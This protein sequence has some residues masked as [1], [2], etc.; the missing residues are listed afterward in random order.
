MIDRLLA[1]AELISVRDWILQTVRITIALIMLCRVAGNIREIL[2]I[3]GLG[4][5]SGRYYTIRIWGA[6]PA[7]LMFMLIVESIVVTVA[8]IIGIFIHGDGAPYG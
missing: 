5:R 6:R 4:K 2:Y 1:V 3:R 7:A 8:G